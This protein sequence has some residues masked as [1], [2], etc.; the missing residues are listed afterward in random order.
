MVLRAGSIAEIAIAAVVV[1]QAGAKPW[2]TAD[3]AGGMAVSE[4]G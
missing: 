1:G 3:P 4:A 2:L